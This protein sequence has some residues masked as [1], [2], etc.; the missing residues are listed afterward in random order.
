MG[1]IITLSIPKRPLITLEVIA[2]RFSVALHTDDGKNYGVTVPDI[3]GCFS[4]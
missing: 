4:A 3:P 2:M 1:A